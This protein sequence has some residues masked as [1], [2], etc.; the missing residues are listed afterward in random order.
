MSKDGYSTDGKTALNIVEWCE[1]DDLVNDRFIPLIENRDRYLILYGGRGSSKSN[2]M[3]KKLIYRCLTEDYFRYILVRNQ[4]NTIK[5]SSYQTIKDIIFELGLQDLFVF[6][7]QPLEIHCLNGNM[8]MARGCDDTTTLKSV[9]DPTGIWYEEDVPTEADFIT[10]TTSIRTQKADYLQEI[11]TINPEVEGNYQD[12]W[13]W[14]RYFEGHNELSFTST[15]TMKV[16]EDKSVDLSYTVHH[17]SHLD[18]KWLP[19][20]FRAF[21]IDLKRTNPYYYTIYCLGNWGNKQLGGLFYKQFDIGRNTAKIPYNPDLPLHL[22]FDF[23]VSPYMSCSIWQ[24]DGKRLWQIDEIAMKDPDNNTNKTCQEVI[25]RYYNHKSG[26]FIYG[27]AT[28]RHEDTRSEKGFD[29]YLI[30]RRELDKYN[31]VVRVPNSNPPVHIRGQFINTCFEHYFEGI[32]IIIMED[33]TYL[34][35]DLL[36][37]KQASDG[38][39]L[40]EKVK[41]NGVQHEKYHHFSDGLDYIACEVFASEFAN[42]QLGGKKMPFVIG[43]TRPGNK[44]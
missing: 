30:I 26:M 36:F 37:G 4:Y 42:Y 20:E 16:S 7:L 19:D 3:A 33:S 35:N 10:I 21:L 29:D 22:A 2:A 44:F 12:N 24:M 34:K 38:T 43:G 23:N 6:K 11:F 41:T 1:W 27:D 32:E 25:R 15:T 17:S 13:F 18:N 28:A 8:F 31:P 39:K 5:D 14:K 40:K 9:K